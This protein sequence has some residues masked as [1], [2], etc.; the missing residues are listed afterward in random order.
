MTDGE[1]AT[2]ACKRLTCTK[3]CG[4]ADCCF[5]P[6][7]CTSAPLGATTPRVLNVTVSD[8]LS[9]CIDDFTFQ[10]NYISQAT[11]QNIPTF[12]YNRVIYYYESNL[13]DIAACNGQGSSYSS[14]PYDCSGTAQPCSNNVKIKMYFYILIVYN[15]FDNSRDNCNFQASVFMYTGGKDVSN[16]CIFINAPT[17]YDRKSAEACYYPLFT[18]MEQRLSDGL[19]SCHPNY[20]APS[21]TLKFNGFGNLKMLV[22]E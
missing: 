1:T 21:Q 20:S 22:T 15:T 9:S 14:P 10:L 8:T 6:A 13:L 5:I 18:T 4:N 16:N 11:S 3:C 17:T 12:G 19:Y 7:C 2:P